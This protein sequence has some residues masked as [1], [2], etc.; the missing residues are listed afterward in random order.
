MSL[1]HASLSS[2]WNLKPRY[3]VRVMGER[4]YDGDVAILVSAATG[5][6]LA[7]SAKR[8]DDTDERELLGSDLMTFGWS[9]RKFSSFQVDQDK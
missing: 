2:A 4:V 3:K 5:R 9:L 8:F 7:A 6:A 1:T